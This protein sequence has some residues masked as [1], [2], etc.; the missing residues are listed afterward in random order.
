MKKFK[1]NKKTIL[2]KK[3][4]RIWIYNHTTQNN[5]IKSGLK[6]WQKSFLCLFELQT[7]KI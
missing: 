6:F 2:K 5:N 3:W 1:K 7:N 4:P